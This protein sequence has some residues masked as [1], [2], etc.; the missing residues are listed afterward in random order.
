MGHI[1]LLGRVI[2][3]VSDSALENGAVEIKD[4]K[5]TYVGPAAGLSYSEDAEVYR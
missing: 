4:S 5:I 2:D 1:V 3:S